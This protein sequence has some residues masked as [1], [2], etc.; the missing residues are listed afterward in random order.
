MTSIFQAGQP[1]N[2]VRTSST[3]YQANDKDLVISSGDEVALPSPNQGATILVRPAPSIDSI[4]ITT[5]NG[6]IGNTGETFGI[7]RATE[8]IYLVGDGTDWYARSGGGEIS[9]IPDSG[10]SRW[11]F[12]E[13]SGSTA[14]DS[15]G[16]NDG[17]IVGATHNSGSV[18]V[19][20]YSLA[21]DG[22]G[23]GDEVAIPNDPSLDL[24]DEISI[25][26]WVYLTA[27]TDNRDV[28]ATNGEI[29][30]NRVGIFH[31]RSGLDRGFTAR[32]GSV[33]VNAGQN[34]SIN[35]WYHVVG[36]VS[37]G[38]TVTLYVDGASEGSD[39]GGSLSSTNN[40]F[41]IGSDQESGRD[42]EVNGYVDDVKVYDKELTATEVSN[43]Y[44]SGSIVG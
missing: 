21:F 32:A 26:A 15:W 14:V 39:T 34:A 20:D 27:M 35:Q 3:T 9:A 29:N 37:S 19:V 4:N 30:N 6:T 12:E 11:N 5:S 25:A 23:S 24:T 16:D 36:T 33:D 42:Y 7:Y 13:G 41:V 17:S 43:L 10:V 8:P 40:D 2:I 31:S 44:S 18:A 1:F 38:G 22:D 28:F